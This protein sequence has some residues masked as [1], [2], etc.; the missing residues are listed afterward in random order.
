MSE[1]TG[2]IGTAE[3]DFGA[4][5][6]ALDTGGIV[7]IE[8]GCVDV[9]VVFGNAV[10]TFHDGVAGF[11]HFA[12]EFF[13]ASFVFLMIACIGSLIETDFRLHGICH[14]DAELEHGALSEHVCN[15]KVKVFEHKVH[16]LITGSAFAVEFGRSRIEDFLHQRHIAKVAHQVVVLHSADKAGLCNEV[17]I[18][19]LVCHI[20]VVDDIVATAN[21]GVACVPHAVGGG[22]LE[23]RP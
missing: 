7:S 16:H 5:L 17:F 11:N 21:L 15:G 23:V 2:L 14:V 19:R 3:D 18:L 20:G 22:Y 1:S 10:A 6:D 13:G 4:V 9:E 8:I 12:V